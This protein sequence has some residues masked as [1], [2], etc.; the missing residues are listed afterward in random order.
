MEIVCM[1]CRRVRTPR[2]RW[3]TVPEE[4]ITELRNAGQLTYGC[5]FACTRELFGLNPEQRTETGLER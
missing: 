1:H 3:V 5:C 4:R 2:G